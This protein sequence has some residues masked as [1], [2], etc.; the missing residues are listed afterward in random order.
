MFLI[1]ATLLFNTTKV[2]SFG[3]ENRK[4]KVKS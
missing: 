2:N 3:K 4:E 1:K